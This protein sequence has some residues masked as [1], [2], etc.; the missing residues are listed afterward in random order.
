M[1][2]ESLDES[3]NWREKG[4]GWPALDH[5]LRNNPVPKSYPTAALSNIQ[6][7][8]TIFRAFDAT[9]SIQQNLELYNYDL[10]FVIRSQ[11]N[12]N[13]RNKYSIQ[14]MDKSNCDQRY[15]HAI[16]EII[17]NLSYAR[18]LKQNKAFLQLIRTVEPQAEKT[19]ELIDRKIEL[20]NESSLIAHETIKK[21][22]ELGCKIRFTPY[23]P[24]LVYSGFDKHGPD[25]DLDKRYKL[26][27]RGKL[28]YIASPGYLPLKEEF[29]PRG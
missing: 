25:C 19:I 10:G 14:Y 18:V 23:L 7:P 2:I 1:S 20:L 28:E 27:M 16:V 15:S 26:E 21:A 17:R 13:E 22:R 9:K 4:Q 29:P 11:I 6:A 12:G 5:D 8:S 24:L 3:T